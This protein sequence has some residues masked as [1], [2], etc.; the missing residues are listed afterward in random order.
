MLWVGNTGPIIE[1]VQG[2]IVQ[3]LFLRL[4]GTGRSPTRYQDICPVTIAEE[5]W[6]IAEEGWVRFV[7]DE[8]GGERSLD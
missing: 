3:A 5:G 1:D 7:I 8:N 2:G 4:C 6:V